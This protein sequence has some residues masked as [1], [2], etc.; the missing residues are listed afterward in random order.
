MQEACALKRTTIYQEIVSQT[1]SGAVSYYLLDCSQVC[2]P[3]LPLT[4]PTFAPLTSS[5][6][7]SELGYRV[8]APLEPVRRPG[9]AALHVDRAQVRES[10]TEGVAATDDA[11][12][13]KRPSSIACPNPCDPPCSS[14]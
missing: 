6:M 3:N 4:V 5:P 11:A 8:P 10:G 14:R 1:S 7:Q 12:V 2:V 13:P 9:K